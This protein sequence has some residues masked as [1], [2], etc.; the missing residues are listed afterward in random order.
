MNMDQLVA[1]TGTIDDWLYTYVLVI[2][3]VFAGLYFTVRTKAV[4]IRYIK[5]MFTQLVEKKHVAGGKS[6]LVVPGA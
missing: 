2:L 1:F 4:Q 5:D 6:D 3:L